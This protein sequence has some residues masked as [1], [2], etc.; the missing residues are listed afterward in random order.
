MDSWIVCMV[1]CPVSFVCFSAFVV[2]TPRSWHSFG[3]TIHLCAMHTQNSVTSVLLCLCGDDDH[4]DGE[5][6]P[7]GLIG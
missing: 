4:S 2:P 6:R 5:R 1:G 7:G 3:G